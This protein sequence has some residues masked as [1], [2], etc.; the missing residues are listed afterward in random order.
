MQ[1]VI[2]RYPAKFSW[3]RRSRATARFVVQQNNFHYL[4][5]LSKVQ[6]LHC[7]YLFTLN[8]YKFQQDSQVLNYLANC[9][10]GFRIW[11][12]LLFREPKLRNFIFILIIEHPELKARVL[13]SLEGNNK[14]RETNTH[15]NTQMPMNCD[16]LKAE[17][18]PMKI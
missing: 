9:F 8:L 16:A 6:P 14:G 12:Y 5:A 18:Y 1:H 10:D 11:H 4:S 2:F 15:I 13:P 3:C 7:C 17:N